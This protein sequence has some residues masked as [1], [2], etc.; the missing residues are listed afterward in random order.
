MPATIFFDHSGEI[1]VRSYFADFSKEE[2]NRELGVAKWALAIYNRAEETPKDELAAANARLLDLHLGRSALALA[3]LEHAAATPGIDPKLKVAFED[4]KERLPFQE[5][6]RGYEKAGSAEK[7]DEFCKRMFALYREGKKIE[8]KGDA[9]FM[10]YWNMAFDGAFALKD[11][12][13]AR[14]VA[15]EYQKI[16]GGE[17]PARAVLLRMNADLK[18]MK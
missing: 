2:A 13:G 18:R 8:D 14:Q 17:G 1:L 10:H 11:K 12:A 7:K 3:E 9:Q 4:Y 16:T 5:N 6:I 15:E